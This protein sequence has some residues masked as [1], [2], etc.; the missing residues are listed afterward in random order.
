MKNHDGDLCVMD[1]IIGDVHAQ[2]P[3]YNRDLIL[4]YRRQKVDE[5]PQFIFEILSAAFAHA[6]EPVEFINVRQLTPQE[7]Y[8][9][10]ASGTRPFTRKFSI[11]RSESIILLFT[12]QF[13]NPT[14]KVEVPVELPYLCPHAFIYQGTEFWPIFNITERGIFHTKDSTGFALNPQQ[15]PMYFWID[16]NQHMFSVSGTHIKADII[17]C[18]AHNMINPKFRNGYPSIIYSLC[19][20][21]FYETLKKYDF[22]EDSVRL[23][24]LEEAPENGF[25]VVQI[26]GTEI[27]VHIKKDV[28]DDRQLMTVIRSFNELVAQKPNVSIRELVDDPENTYYFVVFGGYTHG[29]NKVDEKAFAVA[30]KHMRTFELY[31][32]IPTRRIYEEQDIPCDDIFMLFREVFRRVPYWC[33]PACNIANLYDKKLGN[34][35]QLMKPWLENV[36]EVIWTLLN[37]YDR[38][39]NNGGGV[40]LNPIDVQQ[41]INRIKPRHMQAIRSSTVCRAAPSQ[42]N[43]SM[44]HTT[45]LKMQKLI[46]IH[47]LGSP[48]RKNKKKGGG[49]NRFRKPEHYRGHS[50][51]LVVTSVNNV[52]TS[53]PCASGEVGPFAEV[54][55]E[56]G[57]FIKPDWAAA[58][59]NAFKRN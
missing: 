59:D 19:K 37:I 26:A 16:P 17:T 28:T 50:S 23:K 32:D 29:F 46:D 52:P 54:V 14:R 7:R 53:N 44:L 51:H 15:V 8:N 55:M 30:K 3:H 13:N 58:A 10:L 9:R 2:M 24:P 20:Y 11:L 21:G 45:G 31:L 42:Y 1:E 43:D 18:R 47:D 56:T 6:R 39:L 4:N 34:M 57:F 38:E 48:S 40:I 27:G 35:N 36:F 41:Y 25:V 49:S 5:L 33:S 12:F 22:P